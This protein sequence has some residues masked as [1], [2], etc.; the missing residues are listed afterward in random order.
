MRNSRSG[1]TTAIGFEV[2]TWRHYEL[3][4]LRQ[5]YQQLST[6][7]WGARQRSLEMW[8]WLVGRKAHDQVLIAVE[9]EPASEESDSQLDE[10]HAEVPLSSK[11]VGYAIVRDSCIVEMLTMPGHSSVR[12]E[13]LRRACRDAMDRD[14]HFVSLHTPA[15]D[16][17]H[18]LLVT[19]GGSWIADSAAADGQWM[20]KL[21]SPERWI[22][23]LYPV[24]HERARE[25][26]VPR[27]L[28]LDF[29]VSDFAVGE[30]CHRLMLTRT[31]LSAGAARR[32]VGRRAVQLASAARPA[33]GE[34]HFSRSDRPR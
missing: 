15:A 11:V 14:H 34:P 7:M 21:L 32:L 12:A 33:D 27:P 5:I 1:G 19:A 17:M 25:A 3:D 22:E 31:Q 26:G 4:S 28:E 18:E 29:A 23:R 8:Q 30:R 20:L 24:L 9:R 10:S 13:L 6:N 16:P 2:R